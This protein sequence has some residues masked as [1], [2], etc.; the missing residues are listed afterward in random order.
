MRVTVTTQQKRYEPIALLRDGHGH[1]VD[2]TNPLS[3]CVTRVTVTGKITP[4]YPSSPCHSLSFTLT[5]QKN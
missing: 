5:S 1:N 2:V 4:I 3:C